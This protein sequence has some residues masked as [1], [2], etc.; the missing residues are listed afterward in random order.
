MATLSH[1]PHG[2]P[3]EGYTGARRSLILA[4][5]GMRLSYQAGAIRALL[6]EGLCF[7]HVDSTSGG[8]LNHAM[9]FSGLSPVQM[10]DRW[11]TLNPKDFVSFLPLD[12]YLKLENIQAMGSADNIIDKVIP[13]LGIDMDKVNAVDSMEGT[14][15]VCNYTHKVNEVIHHKEMDVDFLVAGMSLPGVWPPV[16][17]GN[18]LYHDSAFMRNANLMEAVVRGAEEL[19][20]IWVLG[21]TNEYKGGFLGLYV[22]ML[23]VS[24]NGALHQEFKMIDE[25]NSRIA[26]GEQVYGHTRPIV[27]HLI[28]PEYPLPLDPDLYLGRTDNATLINMGYA[29]A[30]N[31]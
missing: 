15:N 19:W 26:K 28:R 22:N 8:L 1:N 21:N 30:K 3:P 31:I 16:K 13:H 9:L 6:E 27:L 5:G 18:F 2:A 25:I 23:E 20:L 11:R 24:A 14:F 17:K 29:D 7:S 4:G 12:Q 10:C